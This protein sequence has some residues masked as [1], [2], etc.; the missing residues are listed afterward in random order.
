MAEVSYIFRNI[1][2]TSTVF[3]LFAVSA[4][5]ASPISFGAEQGRLSGSDFERTAAELVHAP[6]PGGGDASIGSSESAFDSAGGLFTPTFGD[7]NTDPPIEQ[8]RFGFDVSESVTPVADGNSLSYPAIGRSPSL[9]KGD[10]L[11][12]FVVIPLPAGGLMAIVGLGLIG[13]RR[14]R[15]DS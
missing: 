5:S 9:D 11:T 8:L 13:A 3:C 10:R 15:S 7:R 1:T 4:A 14:V 2:L 12:P 6:R